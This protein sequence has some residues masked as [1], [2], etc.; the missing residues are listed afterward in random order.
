MPTHQVLAVRDRATDSF[1]Q[2]IF[3]VAVGQGVRS[4]TDEI[5][6]KESPFHAHP[7]DYD[8]YH[9]AEYEDRTGQL[10]PFSTPRLV[11]IG[12]DLQRE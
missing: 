8:L 12:K 2:P 3:V 6:R 7:E 1:G 9:L 11:S 4:F 5:N 10:S